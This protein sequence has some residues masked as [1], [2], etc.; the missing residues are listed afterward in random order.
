M[1]FIA[2]IPARYSSTRFPGKPLVKIN[3][4]SMI[5][6]V[7]LQAVKV[8]DR[9]YVA[10]DNQ[11]ILKEVESFG[12]NAV[13]TKKKHKSGTDRCAEAILKIEELE[14]KS[15]NVIINIQGDEPFIKTEQLIDIKKAF[16]FKKTQI[17][18]LVKPINNKE[19]IFNPNKPKVIINNK[20]EA[21]YF[22]R[23]PIPFLRGA[24][25]KNWV[26]KHL[27]YKH[28]GLYGF[29]K[30]IL[31]EISKLNQTPLEK[32]ESLEQ[33]RWLENGYKIKIA[34]TEHESISIDT[35]KDLEKARQIGLL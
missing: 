28:V 30:D 10:T 31:M 5:N 11:K 32:A 26:S 12:G 25:H 29:R 6:Q 16:K 27:Y 20:N 2:I 33:L 23:S 34:F 7:Y 8:F 19:D 4:K 21:I 14:N 24:T 18:T 22:S 1:N 3:G 17:A 15:Y 13:M 35:P 9:V